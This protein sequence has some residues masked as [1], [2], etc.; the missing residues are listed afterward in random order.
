MKL[1]VTIL[2]LLLVAALC[3]RRSG[4]MDSDSPTAC[5][6]T[7]TPWQLNRSVVMDYYE[8]SSLRP[9]PATVFQTKEG[10]QVC[11][12]PREPWVQ[13]YVSDLDLN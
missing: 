8:T 1:C 13:E 2:S 3:S 6:F 5:C 7:Y 11:A 10:R 12:S 4:P 9:Q